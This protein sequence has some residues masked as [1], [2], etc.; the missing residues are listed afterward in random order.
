MAGFDAAFEELILV[1][2]GYSDDPADSGGKTCYGITEAT[3]REHGYAGQMNALPL[4]EAKRI[5]KAG[6]WDSLRLDEVA[7]L[8]EPIAKE[9]FDTGVNCGIAVAASFLQ[10]SL[11]VFNNLQAHYLDVEAT[12][13]VGPK[14]IAALTSFLNRRAP[15]GERVLLRALNSLQGAKYIKLAEVRQKDEKFA[16]GWF[17]RRVRI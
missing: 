3:A 6:Y 7:A 15:D 14:T 8:S 4:S 17:L 9:M 10:R 1:E 2:G 11:N 13:T 16:F 12:S 5:Y